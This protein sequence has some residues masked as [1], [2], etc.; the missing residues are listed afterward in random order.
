MSQSRKNIDGWYGTPAHGANPGFRAP[1]AISE[2]LR[3]PHQW[4][5]D[6][7]TI[8]SVRFYWHPELGYI[9]IPDDEQG[10]EHDDG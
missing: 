7:V 10:C 1:H 2:S 6:Q 9:T 5:G 8:M 3:P 4:Q